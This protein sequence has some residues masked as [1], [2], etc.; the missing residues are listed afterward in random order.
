MTY[1][2]SIQSLCG[3]DGEATG[4]MLVNH[5]VEHPN[6]NA[7]VIP[8]IKVKSFNELNKAIERFNTSISSKNNLVICIDAH[9]CE[10]YLTF[11][12]ARS[13]NKEDFVE[14][15]EW[16]K[17][18]EV[19]E[20]LYPIFQKNVLVIFVSCRSASYFASS[21][22]SHVSVLASEGEVNSW[23]AKELLTVFYD[24]YC[25]SN[26]IE[27]AYNEMIKKYPLEEEKKKTSK[28]KAVLKLFL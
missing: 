23:R 26:N 18:D 5:F 12:D 27:Q 16:K 8:P 9:S 10:S 24:V 17:I 11:K 2:V 21:K 6:S 28:F 14:F 1:F 22:T 19:I 4:S 25:E 7:I 13:I 20:E 3:A 15:F